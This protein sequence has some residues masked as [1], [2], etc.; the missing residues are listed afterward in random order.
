MRIIDYWK[1]NTRLASS[2]VAL[3]KFEGLHRG[4]RLLIDRAVEYGRT[5]GIESCVFTISQPGASRIYTPAEREAL[6][7]SFGVSACVECEFRPEFMLLT[8]ELFAGRVLRERLCARLVL[9][10]EDF[11]FGKDRAGDCDTLRALGEKLGFE[12]V[13]V[14]ALMDNG[15]KI[16]SS[17]IRTQLAEGDLKGA[18]GL[19]GRPYSITGFVEHGKRLGRTIGIPT[20]N[21]LPDAGK[22]LPKPGAYATEVSVFGKSYKAVTNVGGNPTVESG[23]RIKVESHL[24]N[25]DKDAYGEKITVFFRR[26]LRD[27]KKFNTINELKNQINRDIMSV[28]A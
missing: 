24:L 2:A 27:E 23:D 13:A 12:V 3:G 16:S 9:V 26:F 22:L 18:E 19:L 8:P 4:H 7:L 6:L 5:K 1:E 17:K 15:E 21:L 11:R 14:P 28:G 10:G 20:L 25:F